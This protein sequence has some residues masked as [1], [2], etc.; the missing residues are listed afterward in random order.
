M[1]S[2]LAYLLRL[3]PAVAS[4]DTYPFIV[5]FIIG[6]RYLIS[7]Y[8]QQVTAAVFIGP[9]HNMLHLET[10]LISL[11][12]CLYIGPPLLRGYRSNKAA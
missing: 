1:I 3:D 7:W 2:W 8:L 12:E 10:A 5:R 6:Y 11:S 9:R 4:M